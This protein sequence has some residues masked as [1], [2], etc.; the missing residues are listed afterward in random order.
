MKLKGKWMPGAKKEEARNEDKPELLR[1]LSSLSKDPVLCSAEGCNK[2]PDII[3]DRFPF[4]GKHGVE[5][6]ATTKNDF[7]NELKNG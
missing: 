4:C 5:Y 1:V 2:K 7:L 3:I 6:K